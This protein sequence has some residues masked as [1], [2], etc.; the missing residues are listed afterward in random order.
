MQHSVGRLV[1][2]GIVATTVSIAMLP[3]LSYAQEAPLIRP[4]EIA[5]IEQLGRS[6]YEHDVAAARATDIL[7]GQQLDLSKFPIRGWIVSE[8]SSGLL[9]TFVGEYDGEYRAVFDIRPWNDHFALVE[10]REL[11]EQEKSMFQARETSRSWITGGCSENYNTVVLPDPYRDALLVY[12][13]AATHDSTVIPITGHYRITVS[14]DGE[15]VYRVDKLFESCIFE[16]N[17]PPRTA[18]RLEHL[19]SETPIETHVFLNL[20]YRT[21]L[22][23]TTGTEQWHISHG[24]IRPLD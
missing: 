14:T 6:I 15:S 11:S 10:R 23:V 16:S 4:F 24:V 9:V 12:W 13:L 7:F 2:G 17:D 20:L 19:V 5:V 3:T 22:Y 1:V 8:E 21:D 18:L